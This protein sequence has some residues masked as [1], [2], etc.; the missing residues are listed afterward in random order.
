[1]DSYG[2]LPQHGCKQC[3][4][5]LNADG[6]HPAELYAGTYTGLCYQCERSGVRLVYTAR[7]DGCQSWEFPPHC[8]SWRRDRERFLAYPEC[9]IC[10]GKGRLWVGRSDAQ[11]GSYSAR[12][13]KAALEIVLPFL[14]E[15]QQVLE[16]SY[17]PEPNDEGSAG[18]ERI[19]LLIKVVSEALAKTD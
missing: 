19:S 6:G 11:G 2:M 1:M 7:L 12:D 15:E 16:R 3:G 14:V 18:L 5:A 9:E 4:K 8:A 10:S 13:Q 17:F